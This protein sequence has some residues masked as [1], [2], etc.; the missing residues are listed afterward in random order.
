MDKKQEVKKR[1]QEVYRTEGDLVSV[2]GANSKNIQTFPG[3]KVNLSD[4]IGHG[5]LEYAKKSHL[6]YNKIKNIII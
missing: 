6:D 4:V 2:L 3:P 1:Q 5:L